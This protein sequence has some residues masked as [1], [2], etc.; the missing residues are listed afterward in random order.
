MKRS[1]F[2]LP[3]QITAEL[4]ALSKRTGVSMSEHLRNALVQY[5]K[6]Q[7]KDAEKKNPEQDV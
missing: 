4:A 7:R 2:F 1:N 3:E 5:L 6:A